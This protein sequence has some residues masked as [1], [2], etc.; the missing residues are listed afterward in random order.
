MPKKASAKN[1]SPAK[2]KNF[3]AQVAESSSTVDEILQLWGDFP[4]CNRQCACELDW[5]HLLY[6][7]MATISEYSRLGDDD[8][9][10]K[11]LITAL[12][13]LVA[14]AEAWAKQLEIQR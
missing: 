5:L 13:R 3:R 9:Q 12:A 4:D 2:P 11:V 8:Q 1:S 14:A 7:R 10:T 6:E